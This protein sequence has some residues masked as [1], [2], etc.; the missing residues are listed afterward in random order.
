MQRIIQV[1]WPS[2]IAAGVM[3]IVLFTLLD[4]MAL[5]YRDTPLFATRLGAYSLGFFLFWLFGAV[6]SALTC[7]FQCS[8]TQPNKF[9]RPSVSKK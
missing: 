2:F 1:L 4:P 8:A 6:S 9:C 3:D 5:I 7:Y